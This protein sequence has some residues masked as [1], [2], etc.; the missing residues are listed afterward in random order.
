[1][2]A[3]NIFITQKVLYSRGAPID[4]LPITHKKQS[5]ADDAPAVRGLA[6]HSVAL[7]PSQSLCGAGEIIIM[8]KVKYN[9]YFFI[10]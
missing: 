6:R 7:A 3:W 10:K 8:L 9:S 4:R 5:L 1:M 2:H